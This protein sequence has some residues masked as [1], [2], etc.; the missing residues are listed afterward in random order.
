[1][2]DREFRHTVYITIGFAL[3]VGATFGA[4]LALAIDGWLR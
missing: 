3:A 2:N 4:A 1:M